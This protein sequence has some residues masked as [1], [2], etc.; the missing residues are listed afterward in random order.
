MDLMTA[1][2][3]MAYVPSVRVYHYPSAARDSEDRRRLLLRNALWCVWL[4]RP[5]RSVLRESLYLFAQAL[6][7][8]A[9]RR[10]VLEALCGLPWILQNRQVVP[11]RVEYAL[12]QVQRR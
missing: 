11:P 8:Q 2:W 10:G 6:P 7:D 3:H 9:A 12:R 1:G 5:W 4:R